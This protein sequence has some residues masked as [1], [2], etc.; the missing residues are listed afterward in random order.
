MKVLL[1]GCITFLMLVH[2]TLSLQAQNST[3]DSLK[4]VLQTQKEDSNKVNTLLAL[5]DF[6]I[7]ENDAD[8]SLLQANLAL[9]LSK[10]IDLK[11]GLGFSYL[12]I[13][14]AHYLLNNLKESIKNDSL[15]LN[16]FK[17]L[18][19]KEGIAIANEALGI[20]YHYFGNWPQGIKK[21]YEALKLYQEL[22]NTKKVAGCQTWVGWIYYWNENY[23]QASK[24]L[25]EA[26][27]TYDKIGHSGHS[28]IC[29]IYLANILRIQ[30]EYRHAL[31]YDS[32]G[33]KMAVEKKD[34]QIE[35]NAYFSIADILV[36]QM[37]AGEISAKNE[38]GIKILDQVS[39]LYHNS[40]TNYKAILDSGGMGDCYQRISE[41]NL[42]QK[43]FTIAQNYADTALLIAKRLQ[44]NDN[45]KT[46]YFVKARV[47]SATGNFRSA[48]ESYKNYIIYRDS[49]RN[50]Q[51]IKSAAETQ[52]QYEFDKK[53]AVATAEQE[54]KDVE[55]KRIRN[56]QYFM[57]AVLG[58]VVLAVVVISLI[59]YRN[60]NHK[61]K[62]NTLL[63]QQKEKVEGTLEELKSTQAQLIQSEKMASLGELTAGI[64][65]EIQNPLNF[66]NNFS[67]VNKELIGEMKSELI[68][69][70]K[71]EAIAIAN[72]LEQNLEKIN[73]HGK[74]A[75][76]IVKGMLQHSRSSSA[77]KEPTDINKLADEY[78][79]LTYHGLRAKDKDFNAIIK[80]DFDISIGNI[81]I[82]PQEIG[83]VLLNLLTNAFYAVTEKKKP[84]PKNYEPIVTVSTKRL[85]SPLDDGGEIEIRVSDNGN[86]IPEKVLDKIFQPFFTTKPTG[87]G[88][89][90]GLSLSYDIVKAHG[91]ELKVE[92]KEGEGAEFIIHLP[93]S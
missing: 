84:Q 2:Y 54:K 50:E 35:A 71:E 14:F 38:Q 18:K 24:A 29:Y 6:Y 70:N 4:K 67:E 42:R 23:D 53:Q 92:T 59:L 58:I 30:K 20:A 28:G 3:I 32:I 82:I 62:A 31:Q 21:T 90:L 55:S 51:Y 48:F 88:T 47:D 66:V 52:M 16:C 9:N 15:A 37:D 86:G 73:H 45:F 12:K 8:K 26:L 11:K 93:S 83:R 33:L 49:I 43:R 46:A 89:G 36:A 56:Q 19:F 72:D 25:R 57:I 17:D 91:G 87:Q 41:I 76:A 79:R 65:H 81:N 80:T 39:N 78:L 1:Q 40:L 75:D 64:A 63:Q 13:G 27:K 7:R 44:F 61:Q 10:T 74:R 22:G 77:V 5:S 34:P 68:S 60:N 85:G 69:G